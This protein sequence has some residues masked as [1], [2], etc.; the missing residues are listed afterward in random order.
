MPTLVLKSLTVSCFRT[1]SVPL[2][3]SHIRHLSFPAQLG[4]IAFVM[5]RF[6]NVYFLQVLDI[7]S[8]KDLNSNNGLVFSVVVNVNP[9]PRLCCCLL[10]TS[11]CV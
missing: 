6:F 9:V 7:P 1:L 2:V 10:Y 5:V 11:R 3:G 4:G 8:F